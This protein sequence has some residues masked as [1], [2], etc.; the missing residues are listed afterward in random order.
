MSATNNTDQDQLVS[1]HFIG[2]TTL[3][4]F[5]LWKLTEHFFGQILMEHGGNISCF[6]GMFK[7]RVDLK[8]EMS[9]Y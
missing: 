3:P 1:W 5:M 4:H 2:E 7:T 6:H 8:V 9:M